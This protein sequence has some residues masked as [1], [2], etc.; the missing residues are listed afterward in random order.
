MIDTRAGKAVEE[1]N[2]RCFFDLGVVLSEHL[3]PV[4]SI[5]NR[6]RTYVLQVLNPVMDVSILDETQNQFN[7]N[8][9]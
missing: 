6:Y 7:D 5:F 8:K 3:C 1:Q 2:C 4:S 9:Y